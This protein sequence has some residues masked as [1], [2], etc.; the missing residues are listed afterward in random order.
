M[1]FCGLAFATANS[2]LGS[3]CAVGT[4]LLEEGVVLERQEYLVKPCKSMDY[5]SEFCQDIH[6]ISYEDLRES[7]EFFEVWQNVKEMLLSADCVVFYNAPSELQHLDNVLSWYNLPAVSFNYVCSLQLCRY[8]FPKL[9]NYNL[10]DIAE[11]FDIT[12][13]HHD[14]LENAETSVK[15]ASL[16]KIPE[17]FICRFEYLPNV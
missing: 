3:I 2:C 12:F 4:V 7:P 1:K 17:N 5:M 11:K 8:H 16:L 14:I 10:E 15:I 9:L 6:N 13:Q